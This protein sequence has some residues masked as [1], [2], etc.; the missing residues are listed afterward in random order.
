MYSVHPKRI[1][2]YKLIYNLTSYTTTYKFI[3][4][5]F[6]II[7]WGPKNQNLVLGG[8]STKTEP[9]RFFSQRTWSSYRR[10][11]YMYQIWIALSR[12]NRKCWITLK[13]CFGGEGRCSF[14][15]LGAAMIVIWIDSVKQWKCPSNNHETNQLM[16]WFD[17]TSNREPVF[18]C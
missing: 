10:N 13:T 11:K 7:P 14:L 6:I 2:I 18:D 3:M 8:K 4:K 1:F 15:D 5:L 12:T 16:F 17:K 9:F